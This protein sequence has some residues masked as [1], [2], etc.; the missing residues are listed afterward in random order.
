MLE[1]VLLAASSR[2]SSVPECL[3][4]AAQEDLAEAVVVFERLLVQNLDYAYQTHPLFP[5][6]LDDKVICGPFAALSF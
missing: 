1:R 3:D 2:L 6:D 4:S 5:R